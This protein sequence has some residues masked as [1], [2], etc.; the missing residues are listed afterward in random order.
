MSFTA[1]DGANENWAL[2]FFGKNGLKV[3]LGQLPPGR[4]DFFPAHVSGKLIS[5]KLKL[6]YWADIKWTIFTSGK[7]VTTWSSEVVAPSTMTAH[8]NLHSLS[9]FPILCL[10]FRVEIKARPFLRKVGAKSSFSIK[11]NSKTQPT[12]PNHA[13]FTQWLYASKWQVWNR[14]FWQRKPALTSAID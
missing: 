2:K 10:T 4:R 13:L 11:K 1:A 3:W 14:L 8:A 6:G 9:T 5:G 7:S 12:Y